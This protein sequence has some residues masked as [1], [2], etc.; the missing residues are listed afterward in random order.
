MKIQ[1]ALV[2]LALF[3]PSVDAGCATQE[4]LAAGRPLQV[5]YIKYGTY[6]VYQ[7]MRE[8]N[9]AKFTVANGFPDDPDGYT[10]NVYAQCELGYTT[11][12]SKGFP[13]GGHEGTTGWVDNAIDDD[14]N[15]KDDV[16]NYYR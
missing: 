15:L 8:G 5:Q 4:W 1:K 6:L 2:L 14:G 11:S 12:N 9:R 13:R 7:L 10:C 16:L 3:G